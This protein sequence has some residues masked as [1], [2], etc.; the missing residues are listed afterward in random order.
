[1]F[2]FFLS[3]KRTLEEMERDFMEVVLSN[4]DGMGGRL[5]N[6]QAISTLLQ[7]VDVSKFDLKV[8]DDVFTSFEK[9]FS[10]EK[11]IMV[12]FKDMAVGTK[13]KQPVTFE[14]KGF[15]WIGKCTWEK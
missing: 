3:N 10:P 6:Y 13:R 15:E 5:K 14:Y 8:L 2:T 7:E 1:M 4:T 9:A 11:P 12:V